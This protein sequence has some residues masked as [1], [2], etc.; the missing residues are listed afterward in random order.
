MKMSACA[1][2]FVPQY[3]L[4]PIVRVHYTKVRPRRTDESLD[5]GLLHETN[6]S[7]ADVDRYRT[8]IAR[9][10]CDAMRTRLEFQSQVR[11]GIGRSLHLIVHHDSGAIVDEVGIVAEEI[12]DPFVGQRLEALCLQI[13]SAGRHGRAARQA[14]H[15]GGRHDPY[16]RQNPESQ[17]SLLEPV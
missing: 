11:T 13:R 2:K 8:R 6:L 15:Q 5:D 14:Q 10:S 3:R 12:D 1:N 7:S 16:K 17:T 4:P 9:K